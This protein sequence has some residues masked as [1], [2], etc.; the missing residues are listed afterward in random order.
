MREES[1]FLPDQIIQAEKE[2]KEIIKKV[3]F[4]DD[5]IEVLPYKTNKQNKIE[6]ETNEK[7]VGNKRYKLA[8]QDE[9]EDL[10]G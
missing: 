3:R 1:S 4:H 2:K 6:K 10:E 7:M 8:K 9:D 5:E